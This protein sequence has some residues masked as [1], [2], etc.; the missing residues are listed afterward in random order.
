MQKRKIVLIG[1]GSVGTSF[2]YSAM[3]R[4]VADEYG[5]ID[6]N[7]DGAIGNK[8]DLEDAN[9]TNFLPY[10]IYIEDYKNLKDVDIIVITAG[11]PQKPGETRID[12]VFDNARIMSK[13]AEDVKKSGFDGI[14]IVASNPVDIMTQI[15]QEVTGFLPQ[16]VIGS[17]TSLDTARLRESLSQKIN[18]APKSI[19]AFVMG[20]HGDSS[21]SVFSSASVSCKPLMDYVKNGRLNNNELLKIHENVWKK[22][23]EIINRKRAT[24]YG[25]GS[26]LCELVQAVLK[27]TRAIYACGAKLTGQYGHSNIYIGVPA[28]IGINGIE[29][30]LEI[31]MNQNEMNQFNKSA[32]ILKSTVKKARIAIA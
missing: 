9:P 2:L 16:K 23:Y 26:D 11:R 4:G 20:E 3:N 7:L 1:S 10:K 31:S 25:I 15:Y 5:V 27:N 30:I 12:M 28:V 24:F 29:E 17:G 6:I 32:E 21:V 13:I 8:L 22:A 14:T 18:V 19:Q